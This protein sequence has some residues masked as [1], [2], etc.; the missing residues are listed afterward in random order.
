[1]PEITEKSQGTELAV[2][3]RAMLRSRLS[4]ATVAV[5]ATFA[6]FGLAACTTDGAADRGQ[7]SLLDGKAD[8]PGGVELRGALGVGESGTGT[9]ARPQVPRL[10]LRRPRRRDDHHRGD[11]AQLGLMIE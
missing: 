9:F 11:P 6:T 4:L 1:M 5:F 7:P 10:H 2:H 3:P 8:L